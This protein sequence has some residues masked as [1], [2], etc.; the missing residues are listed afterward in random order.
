M[1][2]IKWN[3]NYENNRMFFTKKPKVSIRWVETDYDELF[4]E[5]WATCHPDSKSYKMRYYI[6]YDQN[7]IETFYLVYIDG[8]RALIPM[9]NYATQS[10]KRKDY[11][12]GRL[13]TNDGKNYND[14]IAR[15]GLSVE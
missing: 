6:Y 7:L 11:Q 12:F 4:N 14:Y 13:L 1:I 5:D 15:S 9:P 10:I 3:I 2:E 8:F